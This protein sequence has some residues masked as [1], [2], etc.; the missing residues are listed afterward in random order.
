MW[1]TGNLGET[2]SSKIPSLKIHTEWLLSNFQSTCTHILKSILLD[3]DDSSI[4]LLNKYFWST[5]CVW[6]TIP[7][8][9]AG[10]TKTMALLSQTLHSRSIIFRVR[11]INLNTI[12]FTFWLWDLV[13][14]ASC[15]QISTAS[16]HKANYPNGWKRPSR[17]VGK[18]TYY[19][20]LD[21]QKIIRT[22]LRHLIPTLLLLLP[23]RY[24][25]PSS[26]ESFW[27]DLPTLYP[28]TLL[29]RSKIPAE[30]LD[31]FPQFIWTAQNQN[32][33]WWQQW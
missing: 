6:G 26:S 29:S 4:P 20:S 1:A 24:M 14:V 11:Q 3:W 9:V 7:H 10:F 27:L 31:P 32:S 17:I 28:M 12:S 2:F 33:C 30:F 18:I 8:P 13:Q 22:F 15:L 5:R 16:S 23:S 19:F 25:Q 21:C